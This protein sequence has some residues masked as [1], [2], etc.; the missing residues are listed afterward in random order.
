[1]MIAH[2][3][4]V[5]I[6]GGKAQAVFRRMML[7]GIGQ[8]IGDRPRVQQ[9]R[10]THRRARQRNIL[11]DQPSEQPVVG[12]KS[13]QVG[14]IGATVSHLSD[15]SH[16]QPGFA[17]RDRQGQPAGA[18]GHQGKETVHPRDHVVQRPAGDDG[19]AHHV[20]PALRYGTAAFLSPGHFVQ[21]CRGPRIKAGKVPVRD[22]VAFVRPIQQHR[23]QA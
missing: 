1:M 20:D 19:I 5:Q 3:G 18:G 13:R 6:T 7:D 2:Y 22:A 9:R 15:G 11:P 10:I 12:D 14:Q 23:L 16:V 4:T 17:A 8:Q 21:Q